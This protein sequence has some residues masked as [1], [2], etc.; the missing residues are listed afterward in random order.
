MRFWEESIIAASE[1]EVMKN[2]CIKYTGSLPHLKENVEFFLLRV[3]R[4]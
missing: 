3:R 1:V 2:S 4:N